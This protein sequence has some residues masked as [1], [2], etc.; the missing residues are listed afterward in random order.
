MKHISLLDGT[1]GRCPA[2]SRAKQ[3]LQPHEAQLTPSHGLCAAFIRGIADI[4][5]MG[6]LEKCHHEPH[7]YHREE[8]F[9]Q[10]GARVADFGAADGISERNCNVKCYW[11]I[12]MVG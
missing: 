3:H 9:A 12:E 10:A 6:A 11:S 1:E 8:E 2:A 7:E 4:Q 5:W